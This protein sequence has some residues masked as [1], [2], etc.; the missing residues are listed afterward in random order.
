[1][2]HPYYSAIGFGE[3][4]VAHFPK[5]DLALVLSELE[6]GLA[7]GQG[8]S[9]LVD[10]VILLLEHHDDGPAQ[11]CHRFEERPLGVP[12]IGHYHIEE[13]H[14]IETPQSAQQAQR[15]S[16]LFLPRTQG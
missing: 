1:P 7:L 9:L 4:Q 8:P 10:V 14:A 3:G 15:G 11:S 12:S 6:G 2:H 16:P 5:A 13:A